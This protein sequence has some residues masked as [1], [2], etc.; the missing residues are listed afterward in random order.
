MLCLV[1]TGA[2]YFESVTATQPP[3]PLNWL[4]TRSFKDLKVGLPV[5]PLARC[6]LRFVVSSI[7]LGLSYSKTRVTLSAYAF[8]YKLQRS[9]HHERCFNVLL[10]WKEKNGGCECQVKKN[11]IG[12]EKKED[13]KFSVKCRKMCFVGVRRFMADETGWATSWLE[14]DHIS[15]RHSE[16]P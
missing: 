2:K 8:I 9:Q 14:R 12:E 15:P 13:G 4:T 6:L 11:N 5:A 3:L 7:G 1:S 10:L 16:D